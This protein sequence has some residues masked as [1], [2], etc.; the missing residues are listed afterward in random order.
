MYFNSWVET[1]IAT[2]C[3]HSIYH[4]IISAAAAGL[5]HR[6]HN[7]YAHAH[8]YK[9]CDQH[10]LRYIVFHPY[11]H[12]FLLNELMFPLL[13]KHMNNYSIVNLP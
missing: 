9:N 7:M 10:A 5:K 11:L 1:L 2:L 13:Y 12:I 6:K 8:I 4:T 3:W